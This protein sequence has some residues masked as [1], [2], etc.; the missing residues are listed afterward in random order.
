MFFAKKPKKEG[1]P[2]LPSDIREIEDLKEAIEADEF[3]APRHNEPQKH[4]E[5]EYN[6]EVYEEEMTRDAAPLF[7]KVEKY[8]NIINTV[9]DMKAFVSGTKQLFTVMYE[10]ENI[11][12]EALKMMK[13]TVQRIEKNIV[14]IDRELLR[15]K[16][17]DIST[18]QEGIELE[19]IESS[20]SD[21][22]KQLLSLKKDIQTF[23]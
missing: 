10:I 19:H 4:N 14:D 16:G 9:Q 12:N 23:K 11:R 3:Q 18:R 1:N 13:V 22:Q 17:I 5:P 7:V 6:E 20:L 2:E 21:L 8:R 15:P